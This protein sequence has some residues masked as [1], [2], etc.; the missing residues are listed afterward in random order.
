MKRTLLSVLLMLLAAPALSSAYIPSYE[1]SAPCV[2]ISRTLQIGSRGSDVTSLQ[3]YLVQSGYVGSWAITGYFGAATSAAVRNFQVMHG[4]SAI[5]TVGPQTR[6]ALSAGCS[7]AFTPYATT[8]EPYYPETPYTYTTPPTYAYTYPQQYQYP[9]YPQQPQYPVYPT[10]VQPSITSLSTM[11]GAVGTT[12][13]I[14]G[15]GFQST[16]NTV[17]FGRGVIANLRSIDGSTLTFTVPTQLTGYGSEVVTLGSYPVYVSTTYGSSNSTHFT[18]TGLTTQALPTIG[19]V[20]G[21]STLNT[22]QSG[23]WY[24]TVG[25]VSQGTVMVE[26]LWGDEQYYGAQYPSQQQVYLSGSQQQVSFTHS[27]ANAGTYTITFKARNTTTGQAAQATYQVMVGGGSSTGTVVIDS[28]YPISGPAGTT[29][30]IQGSGF[31]TSGNDVHFGIGGTRNVAA[32]NGNTIYYSVP[33]YLST[34]DFTVG[35][36]NAAAVLVQSGSYG[37]YV[38]NQNGTSATRTYTVTQ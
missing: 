26:A 1:A 15:F 4:I 18:V 5:G 38:Q 2:Q 10:A 36:C 17:H 6:S 21:P 14:Y 37:V 25:G 32:V 8:Y 3:N 11:S 13:T 9:Y 35:T 16:G 7:Y 31:L 33:H 23:T 22:H 12:V 24:V 20:S 30:V 19:N 28:I 27:Y 29:L 34:C